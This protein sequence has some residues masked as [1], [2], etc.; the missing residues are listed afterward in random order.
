MNHNS[1]P[2]SLTVL[3]NHDSI[4]WN[5]SYSFTGDIPGEAIDSGKSS[6]RYYIFP[7]GNDGGVRRCHDVYHG[8]A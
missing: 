2:M 6:L 5:H 3:T 4:T 1:S 8:A 7:D